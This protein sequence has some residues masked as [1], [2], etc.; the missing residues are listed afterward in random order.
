MPIGRRSHCGHSSVRKKAIIS[1]DRN[2]DHHGDQR[3]DE[4]SVDRRER[5]EFLGDRIPPLGGQEVEAERFESRQRPVDQRDDHAAEQQKH[6]NRRA[7]RQMAENGIAETKAIEHSGPRGPGNVHDR[8]IFQRHVD[9][10]LP[11]GGIQRGAPQ[12]GSGSAPLKRS[13]GPRTSP[14]GRPVDNRQGAAIRRRP[15]GLRET[16]APSR[17]RYAAACRWNP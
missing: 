8:S 3:G 12:T 9:H 17:R 14:C 6:G 2:G 5:A 10:G 13:A 7:A 16:S 15:A 1:P 11:P 4:C